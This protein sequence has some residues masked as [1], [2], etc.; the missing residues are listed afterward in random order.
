MLHIERYG[1]AFLMTGLA[2]SVVLAS[3]DD[4]TPA[5][6]PAVKIQ[7]FSVIVPDY[8]EAKTWYTEKLGLIVVRD[9]EF[10]QGERF[11][12]VAFPGQTEVGI[13][14]QKAR[15]ARRAEEP[16]MPTDYSDR[17]GKTTNIVLKTED[18]VSFAKVLEQRGVELDGPPK[19]LPWGTQ[20]TFKDLYGN[21]FVLVG[22]SVR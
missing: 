6:T 12:L 2:A 1:L 14:L 16:N 18:V 7:S 3:G 22:P 9:Q 13:V 17:I 10:G 19:K 5:P 15:T 8:D 4:K 20:A 21:S 11:I